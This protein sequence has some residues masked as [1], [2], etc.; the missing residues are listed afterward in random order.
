MDN[1]ISLTAGKIVVGYVRVSTDKKDQLNSY[2]NQHSFFKR[3]VAAKGNALQKI[4]ADK[5]LTGT[6]FK[7]R[8]EFEAMIHDAGIDVKKIQTVRADRRITTHHTV[9]ELSNR[10]PLFQEI[11]IKNTSRFARNTMSYEIITLLREKGVYIYFIEQNIHTKD[12]AQDLLLKLMQVFDEQDSKDKSL[13]VIT[14]K[15]EGAKKGNINTCGKIYGFKYHKEE[16]SLTIIESEAAIVRRIFAMYAEG[17]GIRSIERILRADGLKTRNGVEFG[18]TTILRILQNEKYAGLNNPLKY[19]KGKVFGRRAYAKIRDEYDVTP[20]DRIEQIVSPEFF[21]KCKKIRDSKSDTGTK[22]GVYNG[23]T[24]Y[25]GLLKC[26]QCGSNYVANSSSGCKRYYVCSGKKYRQNGCL[27]PN[28]HEQKLEGFFSNYINDFPNVVSAAIKNASMSI[29]YYISKRIEQ[30]DMD[31]EMLAKSIKDEIDTE[32]EKMA[33]FFELYAVSKVGRDILLDKISKSEQIISRKRKA[34]ADATKSNNEIAS[35]IAEAL[36]AL[37]KIAK[38][39]PS[40]SYTEREMLDAI[41]HIDV[42]AKRDDRMHINI[43]LKMSETELMRKYYTDSSIGNLD[44]EQT[45]NRAL[46][47]TSGIR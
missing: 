43:V 18:K 14:G 38:D 25:G 42:F 20:S 19:D 31:C 11:W 3:E 10:A 22:R 27:S 36:S 28:I 2:E 29:T 45:I 15:I 7:N 16:N 46:E 1:L 32:E 8:P 12:I 23:I 33:G 40:A 4:Y 13:K 26:A 24:K 35:D 17:I 9:Y 39:K 30:M 41:D 6:D 47:I 21:Y 34:Y 5:G 37:D 44:Y